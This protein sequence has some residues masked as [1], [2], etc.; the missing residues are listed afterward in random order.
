MKLSLSL[1]SLFL[2][3]LPLHA[4]KISSCDQEC[5]RQKYQCNIEKSYTYNSCSDELFSCR[6]SCKSGKKQ[7]SYATAMLPIEI[8]FHPTLKGE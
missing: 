6:A 7:D 2:S 5:F 8:A 3:I 1:I 4:K